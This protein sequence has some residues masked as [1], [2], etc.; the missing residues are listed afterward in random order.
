MYRLTPITG[1]N[2]NDK[3]AEEH[4]L[5]VFSAPKL[6]YSVGV[7]QAICRNHTNQ[8]RFESVI[9]L[10]PLL[11]GR[12][13]DKALPSCRM[14]YRQVF[15]NFLAPAWRSLRVVEG[16]INDAFAIGGAFYTNSKRLTQINRRG[17][18]NRL[19]VN[20]SPCNNIPAASTIRIDSTNKC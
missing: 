8:G 12:N 13:I 18:N 3:D 5:I 6:I 17:A 2:P 7:K 4:T 1:N 10:S 14:R 16:S 9:D 19:W 11:P 15:P 20:L